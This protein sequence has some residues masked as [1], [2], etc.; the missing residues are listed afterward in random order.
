[1]SIVVSY[2]VGLAMGSLLGGMC[3]AVLQVHSS[4]AR[5]LTEGISE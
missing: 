4:L 1:M 5:S 2:F 3:A